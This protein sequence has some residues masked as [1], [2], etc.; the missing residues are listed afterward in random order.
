MFRYTMD[1]EFGNGRRETLLVDGED[2]EDEVAG[3][4]EGAGISIVWER[5]QEWDPKGQICGTRKHV[6]D[7]R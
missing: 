7:V 3:L 2:L 5:R 6:T 4:R 1:V